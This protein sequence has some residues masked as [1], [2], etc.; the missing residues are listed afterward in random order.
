M[1]RPRC[2]AEDNFS[3]P[4]LGPMAARSR[5]QTIGPNGNTKVPAPLSHRIHSEGVAS[6]AFSLLLLLGH[7]LI[8]TPVHSFTQV[9]ISSPRRKPGSR[10]RL[11]NRLDSGFRRNDVGKTFCP[12]VNKHLPSDRDRPH[13]PCRRKMLAGTVTLVPKCNLG[14]RK[15]FDP[16]I[17]YKIRMA[18]PDSS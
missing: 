8:S 14:T 1:K 2:I 15:N 10:N 13:N 11:K 4:S 12:P 17:S 18:S 6:F 9:L 16:V 5:H 3:D 7:A